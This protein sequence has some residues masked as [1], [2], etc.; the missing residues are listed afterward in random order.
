[1][2]IMVIFNT[3]FRCALIAMNFQN[4]NVVSVLYAKY[5]DYGMCILAVAIIYCIDRF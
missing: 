5:G 2:L 1:M 4:K 3:K